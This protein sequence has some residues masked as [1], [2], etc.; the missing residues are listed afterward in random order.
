MKPLVLIL[1]FII[2]GCVEVETVPASEPDEKIQQAYILMSENSGLM[3]EDQIHQAMALYE[4]DKNMIG[5]AEAYH[6][7]GNL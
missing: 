1:L 4:K 6:A 3:A 5:M 2:S 7:Y